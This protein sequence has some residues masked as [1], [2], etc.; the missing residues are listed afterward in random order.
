MTSGA[1]GQLYGGPCYGMTNGTSL[2][3][4]RHHRRSAAWVRDAVDGSDRLVE[5]RAGRQPR[6]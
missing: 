2:L 5:A 6:R 4:V 1:T 3:D